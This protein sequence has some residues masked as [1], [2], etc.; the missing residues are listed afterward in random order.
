MSSYLDK[1]QN[2]IDEFNELYGFSKG[3]I[4]RTVHWKKNI[5]GQVTEDAQ[6]AINGQ[7]LDEYDLLIALIGDRLGEATA[8][9]ESGT[10]EE[11]RNALNKRDLIFGGKHVQVLFRSRIDTNINQ[12][13][14]DQIFKVKEFEKS[15]HK[16]AIVAEFNIDEEIDG[17]I[18]R[19]L[20]SACQQLENLKE[21]API[22][23]D[24]GRPSDDSD[25]VTVAQESTTESDDSFGFYDEIE[26]ANQ[27]AG[28]QAELIGSYG[29]I[30]NEITIDMQ[31]TIQE[32]GD[33]QQKKRFD[34]I[35]DMLSEKAISMELIVRDIKDCSDRHFTSFENVLLMI[36]EFNAEG[37]EDGIRSLR[38]S[39]LQTSMSMA[40]FLEQAIIGK[41]TTEKSPRATQKFNH[42]K[43][44]VANVM[45][46]MIALVAIIVNRFNEYVSYLEAFLKDA[47][48][49]PFPSPLVGEGGSAR[50]G[51]TDEGCWKE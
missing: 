23:S 50:S 1:V 27:A 45:G 51:E 38:D 5:V 25:E 26:I 2:L 22:E 42:G 18:N 36:E 31:R 39:L 48:K 16:L 21:I 20:M 15:I 12:I 34:L 30:L 24:L 35:G 8:R 13:D 28:K 43:R 4:F 32:Y 47:K 14:I 44:R 49:A 11:I 46:E 17:I 40:D 7:L 37:N 41:E 29:L 19:F 3:V 9:A 10:A 6:S 33:D